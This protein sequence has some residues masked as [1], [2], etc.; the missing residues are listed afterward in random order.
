MNPDPVT[1]R[2]ILPEQVFPAVQILRASRLGFSLSVMMISVVALL[3]HCDCSSRNPDEKSATISI[4]TRSI[5]PATA[6]HKPSGVVREFS[7]LIESVPARL[8]TILSATV[9]AFSQTVREGFPGNWRRLLGVIWTL[10]VRAVT[11]FAGGV[12]CGADVGRDE[13][14]VA[15]RAVLTAVKRLPAALMTTGLAVVLVW[16]PWSLLYGTGRFLTWTGSASILPSVTE[17]FLWLM[18]FCCCL[19]TIV[20]P[21]SWMLSL[22]A[23][24]VDDCHG[25]DALS[26]GISYTLSH[27]LQCLIYAGLT[28]L[29]MLVFGE[30][31]QIF[32]DAATDVA[33]R[34]FSD[35]SLMMLTTLIQ[36][37]DIVDQTVS[38]RT[39]S[40]VVAAYRLG[41]ILCGSTI[42]YVLLRYREDGISVREMKS[43][44]ECLR[45]FCGTRGW[46][47]CRCPRDIVTT[48]AAST[49]QHR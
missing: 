36:G 48:A 23:I 21:V 8:P 47:V 26:R 6:V 22:A 30:M 12:I 10:M 14:I 4:G 25:T 43:A 2:R 38:G 49:G 17:C 20:I 31:L 37:R 44:A 15:V 1:V 18:S 5:F 34:F 40:T 9:E 3:L 16:L 45:G 32:A 28:L 11:A 35:R 27:R 46:I 7:L 39:A 42:S 33:Q 41:V 13:G 19:W 24:A 29:F